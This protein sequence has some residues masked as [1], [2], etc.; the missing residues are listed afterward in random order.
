[1]HGHK[2]IKKEKIIS[3]VFVNVKLKKKGLGLP[4]FRSYGF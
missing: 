4:K 2:N 1:M 3:E